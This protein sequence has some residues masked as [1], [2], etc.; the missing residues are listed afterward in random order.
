MAKWASSGTHAPGPKGPGRAVI[1]A[2]TDALIKVHGN[3]SSR[4]WI[5]RRQALSG[6]AHLQIVFEQ[7]CVLYLGGSA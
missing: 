4:E 3:T 7:A 2:E 6:R 1:F 5:C